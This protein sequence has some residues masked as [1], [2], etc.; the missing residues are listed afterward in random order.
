[1]IDQIDFYGVE[2]M[3]ARVARGAAMLDLE[4]P[5]WH[6]RINTDQLNLESCVSCVFGQL[7][8][9]LY[10]EGEEKFFADFDRPSEAA[11]AHGFTL[12]DQDPNDD[13][14]KLWFTL[15]DEWTKV[16]TARQSA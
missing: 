8:T 6:D 5:G 1:M 7:Y 13:D 14:K 11:A 12:G 3:H 4:I 2:T 16:I 10:D 9:G 15:T